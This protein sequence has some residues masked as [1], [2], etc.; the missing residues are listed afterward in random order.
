LLIAAGIAFAAQNAASSRRAFCAAGPTRVA[1]AW[2]LPAGAAPEGPRRAA[3]RA[4]LLATGKPYAPDT[5][6]GVFRILDDYA[7]RWTTLYREACEATQV[8]GEQSEEVL[9]LRMGCLNDRLSGLKALTDLFSDATSEVVERAVDA[10]HALTPLDGCSDIKQLKALIPPPVPAVKARVEALRRELGRI[11]ALHDAGRYSEA[12]SRLQPIATESRSLAYRPLEAEVMTRVGCAQLELGNNAEAESAF[13]D[14]LTSALASRH[15]DL[16]AELAGQM[17]WVTGF[18]ERFAEAD[19]W[20]RLAEAAIERTGRPDPLVYAWLLNNVA[21]INHLRGNY[22]EALEYGQRA[23]A[24]KEKNLGPDNPDV[25]LTLGNISL[26]LSA[27]GRGPDAWEI[28]ERALRI[29][30]LSLGASHPNV[31]NQLNN[32]GEILVA[33]K[34]LPEALAAYSEAESIFEREFGQSDSTVAYALTGMGSTLVRMERPREAISLLNQALA[35]REQHDPDPARLAETEFALA[36]ALW[37]ARIDEEK[38]TDLA[39]RALKRYTQAPL[40]RQ[41]RSDIEAWLGTRA[42]AGGGHVAAA[43]LKN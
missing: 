12:L 14:A 30:R 26:T 5:V 2:E 40:S 8:R 4:A 19:R 42:H 10:A 9:D 21:A 22:S 23:R 31:A 15:D 16:I 34:R 39:R 25:A 27:M 41:H 7:M 36:Q 13:D 18:Q 32:K 3:V 38:A 29:L 20:T 24:L 33:L 1:A 17:V 11:K 6:R 43:G 35:I 37:S 28:N